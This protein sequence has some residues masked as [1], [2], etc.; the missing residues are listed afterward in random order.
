MSSISHGRS[1]CVRPVFGVQTEVCSI[2][3]L[4]G[5]LSFDSSSMD[6]MSKKLWGGFPDRVYPKVYV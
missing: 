1:G 5:D 6:Q 2:R 4:N 3:G